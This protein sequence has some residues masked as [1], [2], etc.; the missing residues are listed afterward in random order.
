MKIKDVVL[1]YLDKFTI[2][3]TTKKKSLTIASLGMI[4]NFIFSKKVNSEAYLSKNKK[5]YPFEK[6]NA[7]KKLAG[8]KNKKIDIWFKSDRNFIMSCVENIKTTRQLSFSLQKTN[9]NTNISCHD[10]SVLIEKLNEGE[11]LRNKISKFNLGDLVFSG[12]NILRIKNFGFFSE[13]E[14]EAKPYHQSFLQSFE[15]L[16]NFNPGIQSSNSLFFHIK[17]I[18][19][20]FNIQQNIPSDHVRG[21][22]LANFGANSGSILG[23]KFLIRQKLDG[24]YSKKNLAQ[25]FNKQIKN[26]SITFRPLLPM[27][28]NNKPVKHGRLFN[29]SNFRPK[30]SII[31]KVL[32]Q[33]CQSFKIENRRKIVLKKSEKRSNSIKNKKFYSSG[34]R[35]F[36]SYY[37][38]GKNNSLLILKVFKKLKKIS[39][40]SRLINL[41]NHEERKLG[42][43]DFLSEL[44]IDEIIPVFTYVTEESKKEPKG[45]FAKNFFL[46][47]S[48]INFSKRYVKLYKIEKYK[49]LAH[50]HTLNSIQKIDIRLDNLNEKNF[51]FSKLLGENIKSYRNFIFQGNKFTSNPLVAHFKISK[52][53]NENIGIKLI[54]LCFSIGMLLPKSNVESSKFYNL[55]STLGNSISQF[56]LSN[57]FFLGKCFS[58]NRP[59]SYIFSKSSSKRG[60]LRALFNTAIYLKNK[61]GNQGDLYRAF[62]LMK[63]VQD[64]SSERIKIVTIS[65]SRERSDIFKSFFVSLFKFREYKILKIFV[66]SFFV[67]NMSFFPT[68]ILDKSKII[69]SMLNFQNLSSLKNSIQSIVDLSE[70][71]LENR[72]DFLSIEKFRL[73]PDFI[74]CLHFHFIFSRISGK[75]FKDGPVF[76]KK[77]VHG[78]S[79]S[80]VG[81]FFNFIYRYEILMKK[82][83]Y[84]FIYLFIRNIQTRFIFFLMPLFIFYG[85]FYYHIIFNI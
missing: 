30:S 15:A 52:N 51:E 29:S 9:T 75:E 67:Q 31:I 34:I 2:H 7:I 17:D 70:L 64:Y 1:S 83:N 38:R 84:W 21:F 10:S 48:L 81:I 47:I 12:I 57:I 20:F 18:K 46:L 65:T 19:F 22:V 49:H 54:G 53:E 35:N 74:H 41:R 50:F 11:K 37:T 61:I 6:T 58:K 4:I 16:S 68:G 36:F 3:F 63:K 62:N 69:T 85:C 25:A 5:K 24:F 55:S 14:I 80:L 59:L 28:I 33:K 8:A 32:L 78:K 13:L 45:R 60:H 66:F 44:K 73:F 27:T 79:G 76:S 40:K 26:S 72:Q 42:G 82:L 71:L 23:N 56:Y 39:Q 77:S 43:R